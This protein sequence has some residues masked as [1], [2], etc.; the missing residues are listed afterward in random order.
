MEKVLGQG[1]FGIT[2][3]ATT[4][5]EVT[6]P[7]GTLTA[8]VQVAL[9]EFFMREVNGREGSTVTGGSTGG[10]CKYYK[11]KFSREAS[12]LSR[13]KHPHI[14]KVLEAFEANNTVY[15][16]MEFLDGGSLDSLIRQRNGL[17]ADL[18]LKY[19]RQIASALTYMHAYKMLH[20]DLKPGNIML[21][22]N[23]DAVLI[24]FGLSKQYDEDG[25]PETSTTVGRGTP[26]YAPIEQATYREGKGFP[27]TIDVYALGAT[28]F[29][30]LTGERPPEASELLNDD[31]LLS[32][33]LKQHGVDSR[34][35]GC[36]EKAM[37]VRVKERYQD[38]RSFLNSLL[39]EEDEC[40]VVDV[41]PSASAQTEGGL[42]FKVVMPL[43]EEQK[44]DLLGL[45][46][47]MDK[48]RNEIANCVLSGMVICGSLYMTFPFTKVAQWNG[49]KNVWHDKQSSDSIL[50]T[51]QIKAVAS[52][53]GITRAFQIPIPFEGTGTF[54]PIANNLVQKKVQMPAEDNPMDAWISSGRR[55]IMSGKEKEKKIGNDISAG[56][57][58]HF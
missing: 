19:V 16:A 18:C 30:M 29:K 54:V 24:D 43:T 40:M 39:G 4:C 12:N 33:E 1:S 22:R 28:L 20:L 44:K 3:L 15:Y 11:E 32:G 21:R 46:D 42:P 50:L 14:V 31:S 26:G 49:Q 8:D 52:C 57:R 2:Y 51:E 47:Y 55:N 45:Y 9:K 23:G 56:I 13:L 25:R 7:L 48:N 58:F 5:V 38:V 10:V 27:V 34:L 17:P 35:I 6:G 41:E 53:F 36:V 37:S